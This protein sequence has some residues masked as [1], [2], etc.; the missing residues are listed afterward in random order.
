MFAIAAVTQE[1]MPPETRQTARLV[2]W[3]S[4]STISG[5]TSSSEPPITHHAH[6]DPRYIYEVAVAY[7]RSIHWRR[8]NPRGPLSLPAPRRA[9]SE[10][11]LHVARAGILK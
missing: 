4:F 11:P 9:R 10:L 2:S 3:L 1:S 7:E 6:P 8:S 5:S